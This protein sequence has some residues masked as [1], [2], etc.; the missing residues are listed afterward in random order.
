MDAVIFGNSLVSQP[1]S[2][3][4]NARFTNNCCSDRNKKTLFDQESPS[5]SF[6][7]YS[8]HC[9]EVEKGVTKLWYVTDDRPDCQVG[10]KTVTPNLPKF[11]DNFRTINQVKPIVFSSIK[12]QPPDISRCHF[13]HLS[14]IRFSELKTLQLHSVRNGQTT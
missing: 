13:V 11:E 3:N 12:D 2:Q 7:H 1:H 4:H 10:F 9:I 5:R 8:S 6:L 14:F